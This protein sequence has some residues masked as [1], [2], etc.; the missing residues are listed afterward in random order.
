[1]RNQKA[2]LSLAL[3]ILIVSGSALSAQNWNRQ[4]YSNYSSSPSWTQKMFSIKKYDFGTVARA[5]KQEFDFE[6]VNPT[7]QTIQLSSVRASCGCAEPKIMN[8]TVK[9]GEKGKVRVSFNTLRF[10]GQRKATITVSISSPQWTEVQ[11]V[12]TGNIRQD[13]VVNPGKVD[14]KT[15]MS[16]KQ[17]KQTIEIKYAGSERW[18]IKDIRSSNPNISVKLEETRR[19]GGRVNYNAT[20]IMNEKQAAGYVMDQLMFV[21]NDNRMQEFPVTVSGYVKPS[22]EAPEILSFGEMK[23][24]NTVS[25]KIFIK[26]VTE[27]RILAVKCGDKRVKIEHSDKNKKLHLLHLTFN[28]SSAEAIGG[29]IIIETNIAPARIKL[30]GKVTSPPSKNDV[31]DQE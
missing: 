12:I 11:L 6:F 4:V 26:S 16:G 22:V 30:A 21:T 3:T 10:T 17:A 1:M 8:R 19:S 23:K 5:S 9:P 13:I 28:A 20:I 2:L 14:L 25:K 31:A 27:F 15:V 29:E 7:K 24:G 18:K